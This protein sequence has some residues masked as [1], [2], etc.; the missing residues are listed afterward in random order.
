MKD[1]WKVLRVEA[2][3]FDELHGEL[4]LPTLH[5]QSD[6]H[7]NGRCGGVGTGAGKLAGNVKRLQP[8]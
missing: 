7:R 6:Q 2:E 1:F 5:E 8:S 4:C 3:V